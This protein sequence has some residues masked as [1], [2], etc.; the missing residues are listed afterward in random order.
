MVA[1]GG[2]E[3]LI[4]ET[5]GPAAGAL[6]PGAVLLALNTGAGVKAEEVGA[7]EPVGRGRALVEVAQ[8]R[9]ARVGTPRL[10]PVAAAGGTAVLALRRPDD[11]PAEEPLEVTL[12]WEDGGPA[13]APGA[14]AAAIAQATQGRVDAELM[15]WALPAS[16]WMRLS[17][18][19][20]ALLGEGLPERLE[21]AGRTLL[22]EHDGKKKP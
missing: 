15:G 22:V 16:G 21:V 13:P 5:T 17:L 10:L 18:P 20:R 8:A 3:R 4:V 2:F 1:A 12:R 6:T 14:L 19:E 11:P 9:A 7:L